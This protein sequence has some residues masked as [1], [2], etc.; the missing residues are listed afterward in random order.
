VLW[1]KLSKLFPQYPD[2]K[3]EVTVD[4]GLRDIVVE[5][6]DAGI[7]TGEQIA[8]DMIAVRIGP[9]M[10]MAVVGTPSYFTKRPKPKRPQD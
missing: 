6:Y 1:P 10:R 2:I 4:Y 5:G 9:D 3:W 8:K 7:R